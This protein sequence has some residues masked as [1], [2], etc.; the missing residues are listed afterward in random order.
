METRITKSEISENVN[1]AYEHC[2]R[3]KTGNN[4]GYNSYL[5]K[6]SS[7]L[8]GITLCFIDGDCIKVGDYD[9]IFGM[10]SLSEVA[11]A[12][13]VL[14]EYGCDT[15]QKMIGANA[16][17]FTFNSV[18]T[19]LLE[20]DHPFTPLSNAGAI[21]TV[22]M[23]RPV[24]N[25]GQKWK[26]MCDNINALCGSRT[27]FIEELYQSELFSNS[28]NRSIAWSLKNYNRI[29]DDPELSLDLYT[30]QCSLG[31]TSEQLAVFAATI[32]N[33]GVSPINKVR[34]FESHFAPKITSMIASSGFYEYSGDWLFSSGIPAKTG[35]SGG[36]MGILPGLFGIA[37]FAPP[38]DDAG[39]S[40]KAQ[41]AIKYIMEKSRLNVFD[42]CS[43]RIDE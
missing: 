13:L 21:A 2:K 24:G 20:K 15:V 9:Y 38:V 26:S 22:S 40:V 29:Y 34:L 11:T 10:E 25:K 12:L 18:S 1:D 23:V 8:F 5:A 4:F 35:V 7:E 33:E 14:K 37:A 43:I 31:V 36:I 41:T 30:K 42:C 3:I 28:N 19:I 17:A 16:T 39:I 32:A 27:E 6:E